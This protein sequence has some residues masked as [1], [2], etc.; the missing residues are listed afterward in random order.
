MTTLI[1]EAGPEDRLEAL[2]EQVAWLVADARSRRTERERWTELSHD[3]MP[4]GTQALSSVGGTLQELDVDVADFTR[5]ARALIDA[6]PA[7][8]AAVDQIGPMAEL[9]GTLSELSGPALDAATSRLAEADRKG[10]FALARGAVGIVDQ[11]VTSFTEED[12]AA[13]GDN[14]VL[15]LNTVKDM[16]Q[17]EVMGML[18][19][20]IHTVQEQEE[21]VEPPSMFALLR[22]MRD[23]QVRR[24]LGRMLAVLRTMGEDQ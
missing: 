5:F 3:L 6:L 11:V 10:Y 19:R 18:R 9:A 13:L 7:L 1:S 4:I 16:T 17:P 8:E 15:I 2:T 21:P 12:V 22:E 23:P 14:I 20:T 24:G